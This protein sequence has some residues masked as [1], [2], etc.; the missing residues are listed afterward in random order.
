METPQETNTT[1]TTFKSTIWEILKTVVVVGACAALI[2]TFL[3]QPFIVDGRSMAPNFATNDYLLIDKLSYRFRDPARGEI[4]VFHP[5]VDPQES[6]IKRVIG[7]PGER[8]TIDNGIVTV[9]NTDNP[10]GKSLHESYLSS[11][12]LADFSRQHQ[13]LD[14]TLTENEYFVMGDNRGASTDSRV[15]GPITRAEIQ[16]R[17]LIRLFPVS[18][19]HVFAHEPDPLA[20]Q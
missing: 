4:V 1:P 2:R 17:S 5:P 8:L 11:T 3:L 19:A 9:Y 6:Y 16:G 12:A 13:D 10:N 7:L 14:V 15:F 20:T 18:A